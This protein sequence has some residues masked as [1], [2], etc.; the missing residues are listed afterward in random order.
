MPDR[1]E[2]TGFRRIPVAAPDLSGNE[3]A[4]VV[5][6]VRSGWVSST[7][8]FLERFE[9]EFAAAS[10]TPH[11]LACSSGTTALHLALATLGVGRGDEVI[12]P[13]TTFVATANAVRHCN[14]GRRCWCLVQP[15]GWGQRRSR[16]PRRW[17][18]M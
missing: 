2:P 17:A 11:A 6:A 15:A 5:E 14:R 7:G 12:V 13:A 9:R 4:Y 18:R 10:G 1:F 16:W 3:E 8:A